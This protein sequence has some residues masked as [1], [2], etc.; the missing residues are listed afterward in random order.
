MKRLFLLTMVLLVAA[1]C[2]KDETTSPGGPGGKDAIDPPHFYGMAMLDNPAPETRGVANKLKL[3]PTAIVQE[4]LTVKFL[5][6]IPEY[7][8]F[9]MEVAK[10]WEKAAGVR[11]FFVDDDQEALI[12]IGFDYVRG[13]QTSWSYT[14]TDILNLVDQNEP[15]I[16]FAQWR[17]IGDAKR[18]SD[19]LRAFGQT[20]GLELEYRHPMLDPGWIRNEDGTLDEAE[21]QRYWEDE[22]AEFI[23]WAELKKMV[24]DPINVNALF[25]AKTE[26]YD[27]ESVMNWPFFEEIAHSQQP[28]AS[29]AD[30]KTEL[31]QEDKKFIKGL[32]GESFNGIPPRYSY[33]PLIEFNYTG[34]A[35]SFSV[36]SNKKLV[37]IWDEDARECSYYDLPNASATSYTATASHT[38]KESK[39]RKVVIGEM[40]KYGQEMPSSS[41][42]LTEFDFKSADGADSIAVKLYNEALETIWIRGGYDFIAQNLDFSSNIYLKELYLLQTWG[43]TVNVDNCQNLEVLATT[44]GIYEPIRVIGPQLASAIGE[45]V[46]GIKE[47]VGPTA[48]WP[49]IDIGP[50]YPWPDEPMDYFSLGNAT[51]VGTNIQ[52]CEKLKTISLDNTDIKEINLSNKND[53]EYVYLS[54]FPSYIVG[55][56]TTK[57]QYLLNALNGLP[58]R[59]RDSQGL[60]VIRGIETVLIDWRPETAANDDNKLKP[61]VPVHDYTPV[62]IDQSILNEINALITAKN[63]RIVWDSGLK[64]AI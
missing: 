58:S 21:I 24:L 16:H 7:R 4:N 57:G 44:P 41:T 6:G 51:G 14:G 62:T 56:G 15:T 31:S 12:R 32:Y 53:L 35:T 38:F 50:L 61:L 36:T 11:F 25:I 17:R 27:R 18:R 2:S 29:D 20:L 63:W 1:G 28:I 54:S 42:A 34:T 64:V 8:K 23:S 19:V 45:A 46:D 43:S 10:E 13:M 22:L 40:L 39:T 55:G 52:N 5:N 30:Y 37:V 49:G 9:V 26:Y 60:I 3:W 48:E 33:L 59:P 47:A